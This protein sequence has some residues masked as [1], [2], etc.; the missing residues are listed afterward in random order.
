LFVVVLRNIRNYV[1]YQ[2]M[3]RIWRPFAP[4][5]VEVYFAVYK[6]TAEEMILDLVGEKMLSNQL[7]T[8]QEVGGA[9]VP[10]DAGNVLRVA[11]NRLLRGVKTR[12]VTSI[13]AAQNAMT[14]SPLGSPTAECP[15]VTPALTLEEWKARHNGLIVV[16]NVRKPKAIPQAQMGFPL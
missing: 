14:A 2:A 7:L 15:K 9:M 1:L 3:R 4:L 13:F 10:E 8:G 16:K 6:G 12:Q 5:P 11:V